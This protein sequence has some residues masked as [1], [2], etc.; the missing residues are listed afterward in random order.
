MGPWIRLNIYK[1][2][3]VNIK[4]IIETKETSINGV[5]LLRSYTL[6]HK[7]SSLEHQNNVDKDGSIILIQTNQNRNGISRKILFWLI[8]LD[9]KVKNGHKYQNY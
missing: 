3:H 1:I 9:Q 2:S 8:M 4:I 6:N 5:N 7:D